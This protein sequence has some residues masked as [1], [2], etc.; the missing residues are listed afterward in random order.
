M[1]V[2]LPSTHIV[3]GNVGRCSRVYI[4]GIENGGVGRGRKKLLSFVKQH[5]MPFISM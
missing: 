3:G 2:C 4:L 1:C 5:G